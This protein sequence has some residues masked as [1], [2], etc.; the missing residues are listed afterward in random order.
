MGTFLYAKFLLKAG[1]NP[2]ATDDHGRNALHVAVA[3]E[4]TEVVALLAA[5]K[6][7]LEVKDSKEDDP[8]YAGSDLW[9][10]T[11]CEIL[12]KLGANPSA[13][14]N[15]GRNALHCA[16]VADKAEVVA[17][18]AANKQLLEAKNTQGIPL[19][20]WQRHLD[21]VPVCE[22]L[23]KVGANPSATTDLGRNALHWAAIKKD[24]GCCAP[25]SEQTA[26]RG[27]RL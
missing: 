20:Y 24:R 8:S 10:A 6:Q 23:L 19:L 17:L 18:L 3:R 13:T 16:A 25:R 27:K 4:K 9:T 15:L 22:I 12:L 7:L 5:N 14:N 26:P 21:D 1:A 11:G 2:S